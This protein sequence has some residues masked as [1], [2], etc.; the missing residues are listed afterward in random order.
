MGYGLWVMDLRPLTFDIS[1]FTFHI[2]PLTF[3]RLQKYK[4]IL[5]KR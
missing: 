5:V 4:I 3:F 1:R 2:S